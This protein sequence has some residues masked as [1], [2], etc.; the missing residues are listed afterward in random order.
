MKEAFLQKNN[1]SYFVKSIAGKSIVMN[2]QERKVFEKNFP[3]LYKVFKPI[4]HNLGTP[5]ERSFLANLIKLFEITSAGI[6]DKN[7]EQYI[8][9]VFKLSN[10]KLHPLFEAFKL[11]L[12]SKKPYRLFHSYLYELEN[13]LSHQDITFPSENYKRQKLRELANKAK[14]WNIYFEFEVANTF[15]LAG[16]KVE[17]CHHFRPYDLRVFINGKHFNIEITAIRYK[18]RFNKHKICQRI[19]KTIK[20]K[21]KQ[22]PKSGINIIVLAVPWDSNIMPFDI[23]DSL[24]DSPDKVAIPHGQK[25]GIVKI[26]GASIFDKYEKLKNISGVLEWSHKGVVM[27]KFGFEARRISPLWFREN[28]PLEIKKVFMR[29]SG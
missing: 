1:R 10:V 8:N 23:I 6:K 14:F 28:L 29:I 18:N 22:L 2:T 11:T 16:C 15:A 17:M 21:A 12:F 5:S 13:A 20:K 7:T 25:G 27:N 19:R 9:E 24:Y 4:I 26:K 3:E